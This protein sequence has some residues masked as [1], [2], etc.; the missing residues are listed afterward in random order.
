[1]SQPASLS[2]Q[3]ARAMGIHSHPRAIHDGRMTGPGDGGLLD[4]A[5]SPDG[6]MRSVERGGWKRGVGAEANGRQHISLGID[7]AMRSS[8]ER[9]N[10]QAPS[11]SVACGGDRSTYKSQGT[12]V[13]Q[14]WQLLQ[15]CHCLR[16]PGGGAGGSPQAGARAHPEPGRFS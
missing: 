8:K 15:G 7:C 16:P 12:S 11:H 4:R 14:R 6:C 10:A 5:G 1:M 3:W 2:R 9:T 13:T